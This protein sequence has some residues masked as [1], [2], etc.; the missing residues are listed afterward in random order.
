MA[1]IDQIIR[2][3]VNPFDPATFKP[4]NFWQ[5]QQDPALTVDSIH[6]QA[7]AQIEVILDQVAKDHRTRTLML[8][9]DSGSGKS[10]LLGRLKQTLN[11][12]AFFTYIGPW[13]DSGFIW[14]HILRQTVDSLLYV[15]QGQQESQLLLWLHSLDC[16][17]ERGLAR[18][19]L[20]E[21]SIF[22]RNLRATYPV[23]I[24]NAKEFFG[25]LHDLTNQ[26]LYP[27]A[28]DWLR[29]DDLDQ[30]ELKQLGVK[31]AID[32]EDAAQNI[33]ANFGRISA[34]TQPIV[35]CFDQLDNIPR[36]PDGAIDLQA[37]FSVNSSIHSQS[38]KNFLVII[39]I[40]TNTFK[41][42]ANRIQ[43]ADR[44]RIDAEISLRPIA[45]EQAEALW[46]SRLAPLHQ[47]AAPQPAEPIYPLNRQALEEKFPGGKTFPRNTLMLG[48]QM[49]QE[50]KASLVTDI[51]VPTKAELVTTTVTQS[52]T[53]ILAAFQ[54]VWSQEFNKQEQKISR[55]RQLSSPELIQILREALEA[56]EVK[57]IQSQLLP[58]PTYA[59]Y[60]LSYQL[61]N[62]PGRFGVVWTEE[63]NLTSFFHL[64]NS[65]Q[66]AVQQNMCKTLQ[67][68]R[69]EGLGKHNNQGYKRYA[70]IFTC[71]PHSHITPN[72]TSVHYLATY[73][74]LVNAACSR[75]LV[76][77]NTTPNLKDLQALTCQSKILH[78]CTLLQD[79]GIVDHKQAIIKQVLPVQPIEEFL[80]S[81]VRTQQFLGRQTLIQNVLTQ[82][83]QTNESQVEQ[84]IQHLCQTKQI[85]IIAPNAKPE[86]QLICLVLSL[87]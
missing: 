39:S 71:S 36:L 19:V 5:E 46:K 47:Q 84:V 24:Y 16:F 27:L 14:R 18:W 44:A 70:Q 38:L 11:P 28:C 9:G 58:S 6:Q 65:C 45:L 32:N 62:Q 64:M 25:A 76:V 67:L 56:L 79:L 21:R 23:G 83:P 59:S 26:E 51:D 34:Q 68:I 29:G 52:E 86:A 4:G 69:A 31:H 53:D 74:G 57:G 1:S 48:R 60:S 85:Q 73:H 12:K 49:F 63:P 3:A 61:S 20:G 17:K 72:L 66:K 82:F 50:Y 77:G 22:I 2:R 55:I 81:L 10:H 78:N 13:P 7:I 41:Q 87:K 40:I 33:L 43:S 42:N 15:P 35:L 8:Y 37:L 75:E 80:L 30:E 54:L